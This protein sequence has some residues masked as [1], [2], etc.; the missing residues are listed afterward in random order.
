MD[1]VL[2]VTFRNLIEQHGYQFPPELELLPLGVFGVIQSNHRRYATSHVPE[3]VEELGIGRLT[4]RTTS[5]TAFRPGQLT[6]E[7]VS[8]GTIITAPSA[9]GGRGLSAA[10]LENV[11]KAV[12][13]AEYEPDKIR[14]QT[15]VYKWEFNNEMEPSVSL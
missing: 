10:A 15:A 11:A 3:P 7:G 6:A 5:P 13:G 8:E 14:L 1:S 12:L 2:K 9:K 4:V